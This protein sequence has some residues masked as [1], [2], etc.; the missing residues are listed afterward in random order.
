M[1]RKE[2][3]Y[4]IEHMMSYSQRKHNAILIIVTNA[5]TL[6]NCNY[7]STLRHLFTY[8]SVESDSSKFC[9][10]L[11]IKIDIVFVLKQIYRNTKNKK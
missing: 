4:L 5:Y 7:T 3:N 2:T 6:C 10:N 11:L 9:I 1:K 8:R